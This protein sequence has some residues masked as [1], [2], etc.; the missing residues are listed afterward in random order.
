MIELFRQLLERFVGGHFIVNELSNSAQSG[1]GWDYK[2][3]SIFHARQPAIEHAKAAADA[4]PGSTF[5]VSRWNKSA[6]AW[7]ECFRIVSG[8]PNG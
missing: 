7:Q 3:Q 5:V 4:F 1:W 2:D 8:E 6:T